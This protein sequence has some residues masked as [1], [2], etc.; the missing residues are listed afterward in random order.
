M[1]KAERKCRKLKMGLVDF[2]PTM[3]K[4]LNQISFW[5]IAIRR[6]I[7]R[8]KHIQD[9]HRY[10]QANNSHAPRP[11]KPPQMSSRLWRRKKKAAGIT[12]QTRHITLDEMRDHRAKAKKEYLRLK[13]SHADLRASF[14]KTLP[15]K[16]AERLLRHEEQRRLG[17]CAKAVTG[18]LESKSVTKNSKKKV[19]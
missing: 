13:P 15:T 3:A 18:K 12:L 1:L 8:A 17:R 4:L 14:L 6:R 19:K 9:G 5:D 2:S 7:Q 11:D 10:D 16:D